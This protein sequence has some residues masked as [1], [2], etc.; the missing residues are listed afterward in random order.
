VLVDSAA[1]AVGRLFMLES[2]QLVDGSIRWPHPRN[3]TLAVHGQSD[4]SQ[5]IAH[6]RHAPSVIPTANRSSWKAPATLRPCRAR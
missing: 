6:R 1:V 5:R 4:A 2:D 3:P